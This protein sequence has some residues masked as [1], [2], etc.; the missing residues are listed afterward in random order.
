[1]KTIIFSDLHSNFPVLEE[2]T[3]VEK[4]VDKWISAGDA[5]GIFPFI[6][7]T[8][9]LMHEL[10]VTSV[11]GDHEDALLN[12][13]TLPQSFTA[14]ESIRKQISEISSRNLA[15]LHTWKKFEKIIIDGS[16]IGIIHNVNDSNQEKYLIDF[17]ECTHKYA[18]FKYIIFGH[19]HF[20]TLYSN[21]SLNF[22][23]P[24]SLGFPVSNRRKY[25]YIVLEN[26]NFSIREFIIDNTKLINR[27]LET[28]YNRKYIDYLEAGFVWPM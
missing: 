13:K 15:Y 6:N 28:G 25:S 27:I 26:G 2:L 22:L 20:P 24:G 1:M 11:L 23:N 21:N 19:T 16:T 7:E 17:E 14:T 8:L 12:N 10:N 5:I 9:D 18:E 3:N 4:N